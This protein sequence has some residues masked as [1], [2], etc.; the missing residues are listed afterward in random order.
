MA[1]VPFCPLRLVCACAI[2]LCLQIQIYNSSILVYNSRQFFP[3][4]YSTAQHKRDAFAVGKAV[5]AWHA[6]VQ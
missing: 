1:N 4:Q 5:F 6:L 3:T 2:D